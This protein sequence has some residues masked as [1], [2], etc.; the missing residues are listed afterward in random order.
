MIEAIGMPEPTK[1]SKH[2]SSEYRRSYQFIA[3]DGEGLKVENQPFKITMGRGIFWTWSLERGKADI[4]DDEDKLFLYQPPAQPYCLLAYGGKNGIGD[5]II[6]Q[7]GLSTEDCLNFIIDTKKQY[8]ESIFIGFGFNYDINQ[9]LKDLSIKCLDELQEKNETRWLN[10]Y[11]KWYPG[12]YFITSR[13][14]WDGSRNSAIIY[15]VL[16]FFQASFLTACKE[17]LGEDHPSLKLIAE[18]KA[19]RGE[20]TWKDINFMVMY[21]DMEL[22]LLVEMMGILRRDL[23]S[24]DIY[25]SQWHG[26][27]AIAN[28]VMKKWNI[29]I[30]RDIP[31]EVSHAA[32]YAYAGGRF[33]LFKLGYYKGRVYEYDIRSAYPSVIAQLPDLSKGTWEY[34]KS[35]EPECFGIWH[36]S[37]VSPRGNQSTIPE[38]LFCRS[39]SGTISF[40]HKVRGWYWSPEASLVD[41]SYI[42][43]GWVFRPSEDCRKPFQFVEDVYKQRAEYKKPPYNP[44]ERALKLILNSL[45]GKLCQLI[46]GAE[47]K[48]PRW[49][50][51][52]WA[53]WITSATRAKIY[54]AI[55]LSP[56]DIIATETDA[57]FTTNPLPLEEGTE[58]GQW[59]RKEFS[60]I[61]YLQSGFY[62]AVDENEEILCKYRGMDKD[63]EGK[64]PTGLPY[65]T[66]LA[67]LSK[68]IRP[69]NRRTPALHTTTTRFIGLGMALNTNSIWRSWETCHKAIVLDGSPWFSKRSHIRTKCQHCLNEIDLGYGLHT[70]LI[71]GYQGH[72]HYVKLPWISEWDILMMADDLD[73]LA[74]TEWMMDDRQARFGRKLTQFQ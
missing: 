26:P 53:G 21:N 57:L 20:F 38:P 65:R 63:R 70:L 16:G 55:L 69:I 36:I 74:D 54:K 8:L 42:E 51:L 52:E 33:E 12:K 22:E 50:Q 39:K 34:V 28:Q 37:Y 47:D 43:G 56:N 73:E 11:I 27:G 3:W 67:H 64:F 17:Y 66:I 71:T 58:L 31:E 46:G 10:Y 15:D 13:K 24:V 32:Q 5:R 7:T 59:E 9:I 23:A 72:S 45:Y 6:N 60:E 40:P 41:A 18:G 49:H 48:P 1:R 29:P 44:A 25:P 35:W 61:A 14:N 62:Y 2:L 4:F 19:A 30:C 68:P